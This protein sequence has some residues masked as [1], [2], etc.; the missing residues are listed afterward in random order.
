[1]LTSAAAPRRKLR[2][3]TTQD[4]ARL[5]LGDVH[6]LFDHATY[7]AAHCGILRATIAETLALRQNDATACRAAPRCA[8]LWCEHSFIRHVFCRR[9]V[10]KHDVSDRLIVV[11][12]A[13]RLRQRRP[14]AT[15]NPGQRLLIYSQNQTNAEF[16]TD[17]SIKRRNQKFRGQSLFITNGSIIICEDLY[18]L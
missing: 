1:V 2:N 10:S 5:T 13:N 11:V 18:R 7:A 14:V 6:W 15:T 8:T 12:V 17:K 9:S 4:S 3:E 16:R